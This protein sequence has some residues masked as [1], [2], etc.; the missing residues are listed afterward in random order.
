[1]HPRRNKLPLPP[2]LAFSALVALVIPLYLVHYGWHNLLWFS[3]IALLALCAALWWEHRLTASMVAVGTI[4]FELAWL[5][6]LALG[7]AVDITPLGI[8]DYMFDE[9]MALF[10]R[11]LSLFHLTLLPVTLWLL[12]CLGYDPRAL[13]WTVLATWVLL[14][15]TWLVTEPQDNI[16]WVYGLA[17]PQHDLPEL[18]YLALVMLVIPPAVYWPTHVVL[19]RYFTRAD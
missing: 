14:P 18:A 6:D 2:K 13:R 4:V 17:E 10:M 15:L 8:A 12:Y 9:G 16:N 1:M 19:R 3:D 11:L 5:V 7:L